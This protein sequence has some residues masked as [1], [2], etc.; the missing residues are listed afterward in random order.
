MSEK[1]EIPQDGTV[2]HLTFRPKRRIG[3]VRYTS[4]QRYLRLGELTYQ[5]GPHERQWEC[6]Q[7]VPQSASSNT[8]AADVTSLD[9]VDL[10]VLLKSS[11]QQVADRL[12]LVVQYRPPLDA[13]CIEFPAGLI[14]AGESAVMAALRELREETG[15]TASVADCVH[16]SPMLA[17]EPGMS[18][19][20]FQLVTVAVDLALPENQNPTPDMEASED[21]ATFALPHD[22]SLLHEMQ[23]LQEALQS[24]L[25][26]AKVIVDA[27]V[28]TYALGLSVPSQRK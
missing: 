11:S 15:Y 14:D 7:R 16:V 2:P 24:Q 26:G 1:I 12:L 17:Y 22:S 5:D 8:D 27:K 4:T 28:F 10:R 18:N 9:A 25:K 21:I 23:T 13:Y 6:V 19:S 20:C 3:P